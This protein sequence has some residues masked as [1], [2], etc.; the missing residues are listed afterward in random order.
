MVLGVL[1]AAGWCW[2]LL[3]VVGCCW[4]VLDVVGCCWVVLDGV[5][6]CWVSHH[7]IPMMII[8]P[9]FICITL[10]P[11]VFH[12]VSLKYGPRF[13]QSKHQIDGKP[14][15]KHHDQAS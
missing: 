15:H 14:N 2:M 1:D 4:V 6:C 12:Y 9:I 3:G 8:V 10:Y 5:G 7:K 13:Q 11:L